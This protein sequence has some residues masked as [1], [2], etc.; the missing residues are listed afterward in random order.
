MFPSKDL[1]TCFYCDWNSRKDKAK[2]H[3][4]TQHP[5]KV[6]KL[7]IAE[8]NME[9]FFQKKTPDAVNDS[10]QEQEQHSSITVSP[11]PP[12]LINSY[13]S[14]TPSF[15]FLTSPTTNSIQDQLTSMS[16]QLTKLTDT[17]EQII[18]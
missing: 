11:S 10:E 2:D 1:V 8:N 4:T 14:P 6:F 5:G 12:S 9:K 17:I 3:C 15:L 18:V 7:K 16:Q 13:P